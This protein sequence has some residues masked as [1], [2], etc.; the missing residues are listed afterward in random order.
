MRAASS[1]DPGA[2]IRPRTTHAESRQCRVLSAAAPLRSPQ[3]R[4]Y[5]NAPICTRSLLA[6]VSCPRSMPS[7][8]VQELL[9]RAFIGLPCPKKMVGIVDVMLTYLWATPARS[10]P[11]RERKALEM[12]RIGTASARSGCT[13]RVRAHVSAAAAASSPSCE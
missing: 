9:Y 1:G 5:T 4:E 6:A 8:S 13:S 10:Y 2:D 12:K 7:S 11:R 3:R